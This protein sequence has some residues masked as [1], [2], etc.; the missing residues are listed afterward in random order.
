MVL[1]KFLREVEHFLGGTTGPFPGFNHQGVVW[2]QSIEG[3]VRAQM[4]GQGSGLAAVGVEIIAADAGDEEALDLPVGVLE[5]GGYVT[6]ADPFCHWF[7]ESV[8][9]LMVQT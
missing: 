1:T 5:F 2:V 6:I 3:F 4:F 7:F 9:Q 8:S